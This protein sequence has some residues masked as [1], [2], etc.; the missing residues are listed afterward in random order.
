MNCASLVAVPP[1]TAV[2]NAAHGQPTVASGLMAYWGRPHARKF[3]ISNPGDTVWN[4]VR[5][6]VCLA[7]TATVAQARRRPA[8]AC[9]TPTLPHTS[10]PLAAMGLHGV[11]VSVVSVAMTPGLPGLPWWRG[12]SV[13]P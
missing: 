4:Q 12:V 7:T 5:R 11:A 13:R 9:C 8:P 10:R 6:C 1:S 3:F 2:F